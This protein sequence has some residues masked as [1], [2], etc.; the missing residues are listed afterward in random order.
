MSNQSNSTNVDD[1]VDELGAGVFKEKLAHVLSEAALGTVLHG[2]GS[3]KGKV[4]IELT[5]QQ[6][7]ENEQVVVSHKLAH[8]TPTKRGKRSEE[9]VTETPMFVGK[10]GKLTIA[11]PKEDNNGQY[12]LDQEQDGIR[13]VK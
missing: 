9:D 4:T 11:P 5:F 12:S 10:G 6:I 8:V 13:R 7:G 1:F 3:K 2:G